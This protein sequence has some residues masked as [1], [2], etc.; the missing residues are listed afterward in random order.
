MKKVLALV[1]III[2]AL[3]IPLNAETRDSLQTDSS[4]IQAGSFDQRAM[5]KLS[6]NSDFQYAS[7]YQEPRSLWSR[8]MAWISDTLFDGSDTSNRAW[9]IVIL[10]VLA[11]VVYITIKL[12]FSGS[13]AFFMRRPTEVNHDSKLEENIHEINFSE[14]IRSALKRENFRAAV[15]L[16]YLSSL[17]RLSDG[18][19][20]NWQPNKTNHGYIHELGS[21]VGA[22]EFEFLTQQFEH[23]WYGNHPIDGTGYH[24]IDKI[25]QAFQSKLS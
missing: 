23:V 17:K 25:F 13:L 9:Y 24:N 20:I 11:L 5:E 19:L 1:F 2:F 15:R 10:V 6:R 14:E 21:W 16:L 4:V 12:K 8:I 3:R 7:D 18:G 22:K